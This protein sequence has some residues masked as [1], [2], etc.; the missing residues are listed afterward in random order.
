M[1]FGVFIGLVFCLELFRVVFKFN[2]NFLFFGCGFESVVSVVFA[3]G[4]SCVWE[5]FLRKVWGRR[6]GIFIFGVYTLFSIFM[7]FK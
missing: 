5:S 6:E 4:F 3:E 1:L 7:L 2:R